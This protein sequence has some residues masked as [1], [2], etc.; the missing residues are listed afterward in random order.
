MNNKGS[1]L[2]SAIMLFGGIVLILIFTGIALFEQTTIGLFHNIK[3]D[4]YMIN[5][6]V[7]L[8]IKRD[9][10]GEDQYDFYE[11]EVKLLVEEEIKRLWNIDVSK[12]TGH[13]I[14]KKVDVIEAKIINR[15]KELEIQSIL[16][17]YLRPVIFKGMFDS[18]LKIRTK[19]VTRIK[20]MRGWNNE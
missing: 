18:K 10:L 7:L 15:N 13:G 14:I 6:N 1:I 19:E 16:E 2:A 20:K 8:S 9:M 4:L 3:N 12:D 11:K 17:I 5:R